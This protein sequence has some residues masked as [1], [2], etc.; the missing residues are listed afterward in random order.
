MSNTFPP[1]NDISVRRLIAVGVITRLITDTAV[2]FF[3]P[4]LPIIAQGLNTSSITI[5]RLISLRSLMGMASPLF[6]VLADRRGYRFVMRLGLLGAGLG[7]LVVGLSQSIWQAALG[8]ALAGLGTFSFVPTLVAYLSSRLS[9]SRRGLGLG[10]LEYAWAI[11]G[12]GGLFLMGLL[13]EA[14]SWR[15]P[16]LLL[17]VG[18]LLAAWF[19]GRLPAH[20]GKTGGK[21]GGRTAPSSEGRSQTVSRSAAMAPTRMVRLRYFFD[22]G[23]NGRSAWFSIVA[24]GL[25]MFGAMNF[26]I[27]YG[28]WLQADYGLGA[29]ALGRVALILGVADLVGSILVSAAV[30]RLGKR[31]SVIGG[32]GLAGLSFLSLPLLNV[33][34]IPVLTGLLIARFAFEFAF[35]SNLAL[36]SE[37][38]PSQR[39]KMLSIGAAFALMGTTIA[40]LVGPLLLEQ[41]GLVGLTTL[42]GVCMLLVAG[43]L[44]WGVRELVDDE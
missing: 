10:I 36:M 11:A 16:L 21:T 29:A 25:I 18:L 37:Q 23:Q 9:Y 3:F 2:Q 31:R 27:N 43:L 41:T 4:F 13:I 8:M 44:W 14:T 42:C 33:A 1:K 12:I 34:L 20:S 38:I 19:Y 6:G 22:L 15:E 32:A 7:Y 17:A 5:G 26:F 28:S 35:V 39:G 24:N 40:G 30:D